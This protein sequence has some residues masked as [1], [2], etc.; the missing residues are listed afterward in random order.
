MR[1]IRHSK[2]I[3]NYILN[4]LS[5]LIIQLNHNRKHCKKTIQDYQ[6]SK[7]IWNTLVHNNIMHLYFNRV[8]FLWWSWKG[9]WCHW[10]HKVFVWIAKCICLNFARYLSESESGCL[11]CDGHEKDIDVTD[12][13]SVCQTSDKLSP[14]FFQ[15]LLNS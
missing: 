15:L 3:L 5:T 7:N 10:L 8:V 4:T 9:Y 1:I 12:C 14:D 2:I 6:T 13:T 11:F